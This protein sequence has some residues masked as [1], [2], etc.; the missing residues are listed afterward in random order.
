MKSGP[1]SVIR[2]RM[3]SVVVTVVMGVLS[4]FLLSAKSEPNSTNGVALSLDLINKLTRVFGTS[5]G[6]SSIE[7]SNPIEEVIKSLEIPRVVISDIWQTLSHYINRNDLN[8]F[9]RLE[10][11]GRDIISGFNEREKGTVIF[12]LYNREKFETNILV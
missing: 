4:C 5:N 6:S 9:E 7:L 3:K 2:V 11:I 12:Y 10:D 1:A 8:S